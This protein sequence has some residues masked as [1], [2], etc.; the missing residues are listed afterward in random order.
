MSQVFEKRFCFL[1]NVDVFPRGVHWSTR[2]SIL[3]ACNNVDLV[4]KSC[5]DGIEAA[6]SFP[7]DP[8]TQDSTIFGDYVTPETR[9][10]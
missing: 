3:R 10:L 5:G 7:D 8:R 9:V 2:P 6:S 4:G 1:Q